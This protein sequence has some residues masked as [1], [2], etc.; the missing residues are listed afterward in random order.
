MSERRSN[1]AS[2]D[3]AVAVVLDLVHPG[4]GAVGGARRFVGPDLLNPFVR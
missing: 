4:P 2:L 1:L 3:D